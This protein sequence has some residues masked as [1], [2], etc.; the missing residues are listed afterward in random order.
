MTEHAHKSPTATK[1]S[2][3][4]SLKLS[5][6]TFVGSFPSLELLPRNARPQIALAG[7]SNVGKSTLLNSL[8]GQKGIAKVSS[9]P[10][11]TRSLNFFLINDK[12]YLVDLPGYGYAKVAKSIKSTWGKMIEDYLTSGKQLAGLI[13]LLDSRRDPSDDDIEL[14]RWLSKRQ[15]PVLCVVTKA[16]KINRDLLNRKIRQVESELQLPALP[17]SSMTGTGKNE[18]VAAI[19][20][21]VQEYSNR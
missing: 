17:F 10:G 20:E 12:F 3:S 21:L 9:T 11:K 18:L 4:T 19:R 5:P 1:R 13:L 8:V 7:R 15:L 6:C 16:D 14:L 2:R